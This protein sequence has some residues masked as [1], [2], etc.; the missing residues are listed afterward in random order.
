MRKSLFCLL[1]L[2]MC[3]APQMA[4]AKKVPQFRFHAD[5]TFKIVQVTDTHFGRG[6]S[7]EE[8][9]FI[10]NQIREVARKEKADIVIF[11]GDNIT[12]CD[13][14]N[15]WQQL[16][17]SFDGLDTPFAVTYGNHDREEQLSDFDL[18]QCFVNHPNNINTLCRKGYLQD[19]AIP[20]LSSKGDNTA[21]V[22]YVMDSG[23]YSC[24]S[25][26]WDY[27]WITHD[28]IHWYVEKSRSFARDN[29]DVPVPSY[30]FCHIPPTEFYEA[31]SSKLISG[32]RGEPECPGELNSG[33]VS[34]FEENGDVHGIFVGHDH[35]NDYVAQTGGIA[36]VY[37]RNSWCRTERDVPGNGLRVIC[38]SEGDF[39]FHTWVR[40]P[41]GIANDTRFQVPADF[42]LRPATR[43]KHLKP[44][45]QRTMYSNVKEVRE[46]AQTATPGATSIVPT[47]R[48]ID[49]MGEGD[50]GAVQ[51]GYLYV[52][53]TGAI[54][55]HL[56]AND[57]GIVTI[58]DLTFRD[59]DYGRGQLKMNL[60][61]GYHPIRILTKT[62][63]G[64]GCWCKLMWRDQYQTRYH[65]IPAKY[66][67]HQEK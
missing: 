53:Q 24:V 41:N 16:L 60:Q 37:G 65:E 47:P 62:N 55:L 7:P 64:G 3:M 49:K 40:E 28:Q 21:A 51:E 44:G 43:A 36:M 57:A 23:D 26:Y 2:L 12:S 17:Q 67:F 46:I 63:N 45:L 19:L 5:G 29:K 9:A 35:A 54:S 56:S 25:T 38:L 4:T 22:L 18:P 34:A 8:K 42:R 20:V 48:M 10:T 50:Y 11:T 14:Q 52:P 66:F 1:T 13:T 61:K 30:L 31:Y 15:Q 59:T 6:T 27:G 58:D 33:I 32:V 39:G